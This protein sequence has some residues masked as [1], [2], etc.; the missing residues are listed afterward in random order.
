MNEYAALIQLLT[1]AG[2]P[3]GASVDDMLEVLGLPEIGRTVLFHRLAS[4]QKALT[5]LGMKIKHNPISH[6]F[7]LEG[8]VGYESLFEASHLSDKLAAT[9]L[10]VVTLAYQE[11]GWVSFSRVKEFRKK[12][13]KGI[14]EDF[15]ELTR[16]GYLEIDQVGKRVRPGLRASFEMDFEQF[17][18][19]LAT[20]TP[21]GSS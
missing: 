7:Y 21:S 6:V 9:L 19:K 18:M 17:F 2:N 1:K 15:R 10:V 12:S 3:M 20:D 11:G 4:L 14:K 16:L 5:P 8:S 13:M